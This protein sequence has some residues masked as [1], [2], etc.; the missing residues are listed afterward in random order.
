MVLR[1]ATWDDVDA[2]VDVQERGAVQGL[3]H[4]SPQ[5]IHPFPRT[6]VVARWREEIADPAVR[7]YVSEAEEGGLNGFAAIR[8]DELLHFGT[9]PETWGTGL[10]GHL[11]TDL[12]G[13]FTRHD[14]G[15]PLRLRL[16]VFE[17]NTR[18]RRFYEKSGWTRTSRR[19]R[20]SFPPYPVL[21]EY[22]R[23]QP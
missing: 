6:A 10:A 5:D 2:L 13:R 17:Q 18:A 21:I 12:L 19:S 11:L 14:V 16:R 1:E 20:S 15:S 9:A 8:G 4:V 3:A 22:E 23:L 7:C